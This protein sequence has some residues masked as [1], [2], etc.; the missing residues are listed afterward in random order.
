MG[1]EMDFENRHT[2][3][4]LRMDQREHR[5]RK[6]SADLITR[7]RVCHGDGI[8]DKLIADAESSA[9]DDEGRLWA[10]EAHFQFM[11]GLNAPDVT[12]QQWSAY[13]GEYA[14]RSRPGRRY[15]SAVLAVALKALVKATDAVFGEICAFAVFNGV[16]C[17]RLSDA[18][19]FSIVT[20]A[21]DWLVCWLRAESMTERSGHRGAFAR[22]I[23]WTVSTGDRRRPSRW[24]SLLRWPCGW[25]RSRL[26]RRRGLPPSLPS[27]S[28]VHGRA[29]TT[30]SFLPGT[31]ARSVR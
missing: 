30:W 29:V 20:V 2:T 24:C 14:G 9:E 3:A 25:R 21:G 28:P 5:K 16:R 6:R 22:S 8:W 4:C 11:K 31:C 17:G 12:V 13:A 10:A 15:G 18:T 27:S 26:G 23:P 7:K 19:K 1:Y